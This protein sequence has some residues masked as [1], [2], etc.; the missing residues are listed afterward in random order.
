MEP[1]RIPLIAQDICAA[2]A[3]LTGTFFPAPPR[4]PWASAILPEP[5]LTYAL[6]L[7]AVLTCLLLRRHWPIVS[8]ITAGLT[9]ATSMT[10]SP[11]SFP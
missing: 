4:P 3:V 5:G 6:L 11:T 1:R 10:L 7:A 9:F 2:L 8:V